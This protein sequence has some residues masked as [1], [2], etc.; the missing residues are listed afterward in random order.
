MVGWGHH[1]NPCWGPMAHNACSLSSG[2]GWSSG[3]P[4][5][6]ELYSPSWQRCGWVA[7]VFNSS[8][9]RC[10]RWLG[11]PPRQP[12][13]PWICQCWSGW[14]QSGLCWEWSLYRWWWHLLLQREW[15]A[16]ANVL[17]L[18]VAY[19]LGDNVHE[20]SP[21]LPDILEPLTIISSA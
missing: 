14:W 16:E 2:R 18:N 6:G 15:L 4:W 17:V 9:P 1:Q 12:F 5:H 3:R 20:N 7:L 21:A 10:S 11:M 8:W 13:W 19:Q